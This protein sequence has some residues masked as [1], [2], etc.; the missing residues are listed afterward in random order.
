MFKAIMCILGLALALTLVVIL[1]GYVDYRKEMNT[2]L[3][4]GGIV[5]KSTTGLKC[6]PR[7]RIQY[8]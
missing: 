3:D 7:G 8:I 6:V 1:S 5:V 2:C 4:S